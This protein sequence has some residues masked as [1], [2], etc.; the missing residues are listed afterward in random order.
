MRSPASIVMSASAKPSHLPVSGNQALY[1]ASLAQN[2]R[3]VPAHPRRRGRPAGQPDALGGQG[4]Q[5]EYA[6]RKGGVGLRVQSD[7]GQVLSS[8]DHGRDVARA[9]RDAADDAVR[10]LRGTAV[11][12]QDGHRR[13]A[14]GRERGAR[15]LPARREL[16]TALYRGPSHQE[17]FLG[18][19]TGAQRSAERDSAHAADFGTISSITPGSPLLMTTTTIRPRPA[20]SGNRRGF[21]SQPHPFG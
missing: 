11:A 21:Q 14:E 5:F 7:R 17:V 20:P 13:H 19:Q 15:A 2:R 12:A 1:T 4:D 10:P 3:Q 16:L 6:A 9:V 18:E 8:G